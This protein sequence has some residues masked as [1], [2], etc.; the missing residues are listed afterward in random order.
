MAVKPKNLTDRWGDE[1]GYLRISD[2]KNHNK[3]A[4]NTVS[5][6]ELIIEGWQNEEEYMK[7]VPARF[8]KAVILRGKDLSDPMAAEYA[9]AK[10]NLSEFEGCEDII[11]IEA[12][13]LDETDLSLFVGEA[14]TLTASMS[15]EE[16]TDSTIVWASSDESVATVEDGTVSAVSAGFCKIT[17]SDKYGR[18]SATCNVIV[19]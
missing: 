3:K 19:G 15:P 13:E 9:F 10:E 4:T 11:D 12:I 5:R 14:I 1:I 7:G 18:V 8:V 6:K 17:A 16:P 2:G